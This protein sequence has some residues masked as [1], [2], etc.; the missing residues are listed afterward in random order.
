MTY[1]QKYAF[2]VKQK[3]SFKVFNMI[4][5]N[6][7]AKIIVKKICDCKSKFNAATQNSNPSVKSIVRAKKLQ[8]ESC[9]LHL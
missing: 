3:K 8:L 9:H 7:E 2:P 5:N 1:L 4:K 6:N